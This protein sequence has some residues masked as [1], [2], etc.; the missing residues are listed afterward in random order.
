[1]KNKRFLSA[2][3]TVVA[4]AFLCAPAHAQTE[5]TAP[6]YISAAI[7]MFDVTDDDTATSL[8][9][10]YRSGAPVYFE[11]L[12]AW[13]GALITTD[14]TLWGGGGLL[15]DL[16]L[17]DSL[18]V[19]PSLGVGLYDEGDSDK[20]L[21]FPIQFRSQLEIGYQ[22]P[23][24]G[25]IG[26]SFAHFSNASLGDHNPGTETLNLYYHVPLDSFMN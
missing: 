15:Y 8:R 7:G 16:Q 5:K 11:D 3:S 2:L 10:E 19:T 1:M 12:H 26:L 13:G 4:G 14:M 22:F 18:Y 17:T 25:R 23:S 6:D 9:L 20:D 21:D 24:Q